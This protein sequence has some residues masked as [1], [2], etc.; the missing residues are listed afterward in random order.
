MPIHT[1]CEL[2]K[3]ETCDAFHRVAEAADCATAERF[4]H[5]DDLRDGE[6]VEAGGGVCPNCGS[7]QIEGDSV[8]FEGASMSQKIGCNEC[9]AEWWDI[10]QLI[11]YAELQAVTLEET[12]KE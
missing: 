9:G 4:A 8:N 2:V 6:Y 3:C 12:N 10:Y 5:E 7:D 1:D 11:G